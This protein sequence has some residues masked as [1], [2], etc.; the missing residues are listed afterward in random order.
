MRIRFPRNCSTTKNWINRSNNC[1]RIITS[2]FTKQYGE[3]EISKQNEVL[4]I[5]TCLIVLDSD[6]FLVA[7]QMPEGLFLFA[8]P[9][10]DILKA[11]V[12]PS[13]SFFLYQW[14][15]SF[16]LLRQVYQRRRR[17]HGWC[18]VW[19]LLYRWFRCSSIE[20][21]LVDSLWAQLSW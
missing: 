8:C 2:K 16:S 4:S 15:G 6:W 17:D 18:R 3:F 19:C 12:R 11:F 20:M 14:F 1:P 21:W 10:A 13:I 9:I 5:A 7:M